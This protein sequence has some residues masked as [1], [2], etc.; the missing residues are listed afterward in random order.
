MPHKVGNVVVTPMPGD[1]VQPVIAAFFDE[2][3]A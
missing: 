1:V 3:R 2:K